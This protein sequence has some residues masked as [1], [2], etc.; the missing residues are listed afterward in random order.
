MPWQQINRMGG[1]GNVMV[2]SKSG[3]TYL[4][5]VEYDYM[6]ESIYEQTVNDAHDHLT[7]WAWVDFDGGDPVVEDWTRTRD[8]EPPQSPPWE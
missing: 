8:D 2:E 4:A 3:N 1:A 6:E 5:R 7:F